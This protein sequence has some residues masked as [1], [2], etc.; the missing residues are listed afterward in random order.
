M[1]K[2]EINKYKEIKRISPSQFYSMKKCSYKTLLAE[3]FDKKPLLPI[4]PNAKFG[5][6]LH[7]IFELINNNMI[8]NEEEFNKI[9]MQQVIEEEKKLKKDGF[10]F[11]VPLHENIKD[12][13][14]KKVKL[15]RYLRQ[16]KQKQ[17]VRQVTADFASEKWYESRDKLVGGIIDLVI[18]S[19]EG[20]EIIDFKSGRITQDDLDD[21]GVLL[22][23]EG[24]Q[25][26]LKLYAYL[27][28]ENTQKY[29]N[30]LSLI[31]LSNIKHIVDFSPKECEEVF[32]EAKQLLKDTN[33]SI[34]SEKYNV[35][36]S[37][38]N[39]KY[40]L[41][42]PACTFYIKLLDNN[43]YSFND[44]SGK[45]EKVMQ[46]KN[47]DISVFLQNVNGQ[48][49]VTGFPEEKFTELEETQLQYINIFNLYK[50]EGDGRYSA[51]KTTMCYLQ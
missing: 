34:N 29:P 25:I 1:D 30:K 48:C 33:E 11:F 41:Y 43:A 7:K 39:C 23:N 31:D 49:V 19:E 16:K 10:G 8:N 18:E 4:S 9:F 47:G 42:R 6:V 15:K 50:K 28:F 13:G 5:N 22:I 26:Q 12:F 3:A 24:Y 17:S 40:C 51:L 37:E 45:V 2:I 46:Y 32:L 35:N 21:Q 44:I 14:L 36:P 38:D 20:I 27:Y